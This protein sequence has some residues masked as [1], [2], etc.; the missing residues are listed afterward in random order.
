MFQPTVIGPDMF[1]AAIAIMLFGATL[2]RLAVVW[3][4]IRA[5]RYW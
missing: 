2:T 5:V 4:G 3:F 1:I